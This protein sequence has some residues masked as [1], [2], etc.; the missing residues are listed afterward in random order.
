M[1]WMLKPIASSVQRIISF[2]K[3]RSFLPFASSGELSGSFVVMLRKPAS[4]VARKRKPF[5]GALSNCAFSQAD[6][7]YSFQP[8]A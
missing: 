3:V 7:S 2:G 8:C 5:A 6:S 4:Q 1:I